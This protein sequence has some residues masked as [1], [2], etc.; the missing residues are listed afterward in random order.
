[1]RRALF[2]SVAVAA[3][4]F[5]SGCGSASNSDVVAS[6]DDAELDRDT[7]QQIVNDREA[8]SGAP[9]DSQPGS[10]A[11]RTDG[12]TA[13]D[14]VSQWIA[15]ELVRSDLASRG[16]ELPE[17]DTS[18]TGDARFSADYQ[19]A[20]AAFVNQPPEALADED[21]KEWYAQGP[22]KSGIACVQHIQVAEVSEAEHVIER[23]NAGEAFGDVAFD[24]S[25]DTQTAGQGGALG[26]VAVSAFTD[27]FV[28]AALNND[29]GVISEPVTSSVGI[30]VVRI[31]PFDELTPNDMVG[32]RLIALGQW[33]D[34]ETDPEIGVWKWVQ[35]EQLG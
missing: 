7:F 29:F 24:T 2:L 34:V 28:D 3:V 10:D 5:T 15:L 14:V 31:L 33:H 9:V 20:G 35:V 12:D 21:L 11:A 17:P 19:A 26:C 32:A 22:T 4:L 6:V 8:A 16:V 1:M 23:L 30:H 18:L 27:D 13:R 25:L